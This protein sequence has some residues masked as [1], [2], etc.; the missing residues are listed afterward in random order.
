ME[1]SV[2]TSR[3]EF[4]LSKNGTVIYQAAVAKGTGLIHGEIL[5]WKIYLHGPANEILVCITY[6]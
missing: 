5:L 6:A 3:L 4:F 1:M 2:K